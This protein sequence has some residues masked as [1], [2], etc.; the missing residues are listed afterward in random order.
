MSRP[1]K[2]DGTPDKRFKCNREQVQKDQSPINSASEMS[3]PEIFGTSYSDFSPI[4][5]IYQSPL[6]F[7]EHS[8]RNQANSRRESQAKPEPRKYDSSDFHFNQDGSVSKASKAVKSKDIILNEDG[9]VNRRSP[10]VLRGNLVLTSEGNPDR[11]VHQVEIPINPSEYSTADYRQKSYQQKF[12]REN[13][14]PKDYDVSHIVDLELVKNILGSKPGPH[15]SKE[16]LREDLKPINELL[17][18]RPATVNRSNPDN[19]DNDRDMARRIFALIKGDRTIRVKRA[20]K[21]IVIEMIE[22]LQ[23][24][25]PG[26]MNNTIQYVLETLESII[27]ILG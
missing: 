4:Y 24:I 1:L 16:Q 26:K 13:N 23:S 11:R 25:P 20:L 21:K 9:T 22:A 19:P 8:P 6:S 3:S 12:R 5:G 15:L 10:A 14:V 2:K 17:E 27:P 18:A 7:C